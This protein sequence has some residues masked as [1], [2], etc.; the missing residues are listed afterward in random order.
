MTDQEQ[1]DTVRHARKVPDKRLC[2]YRI[3]SGGGFDMWAFKLSLLKERFMTEQ[4]RKSKRRYGVNRHFR[5][6][7][8][9]RV[10][11]SQ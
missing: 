5:E 2:R 4:K 3:F 10:R 1:E 7:P 11:E 9:E 6:I 8:G